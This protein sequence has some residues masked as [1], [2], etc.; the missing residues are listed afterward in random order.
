VYP[1][2]EAERTWNPRRVEQRETRVLEEDDEQA[3]QARGVANNTG[4]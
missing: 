4:V 3:R 2:R 1:R